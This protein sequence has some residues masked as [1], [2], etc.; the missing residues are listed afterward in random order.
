MSDGVLLAIHD[1][2]SARLRD[3]RVTDANVRHD[4][5]EIVRLAETVIDPK[6]PASVPLV[7]A[8]PPP[9]DRDAVT[10]LHGT[11]VEKVR[12]Q[13]AAQPTGMH[14]DYIVLTEEERRRGF[15]R[16]VR[17]SYKH[18]GAPGPKHPLRDLTPEE[19]ERY[20]RFGYVKFEAYPKDESTTINGM[21]WTQARL[22]AIGKGCGSVTTMGQ[23]LAETYAR[24]PG[25]YGAT[26]CVD[27]G[28]HKPVGAAGEFVW[29]GTE[30]RVGT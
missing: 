30:E 14:S 22:D 1:L 18:V 28:V 21:Y 9:V 7:Q 17:R 24:D 6:A 11:P 2:A 27:C 3:E 23:A 25:F 29:D 26:F 15:V 20:E 4:L 10:T 16:P 13:H 19:H 5:A 12:E 8:P